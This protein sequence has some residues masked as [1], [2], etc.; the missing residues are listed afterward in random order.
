MKWDEC[1]MCGSGDLF[2]GGELEQHIGV[3]GAPGPATVVIGRVYTCRC[4]AWVEV[5][6]DEF[7]WY[8]MENGEEVEVNE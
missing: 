6:G 2:D 5:V 3:C 4:G 7:Q 1:P 8:V